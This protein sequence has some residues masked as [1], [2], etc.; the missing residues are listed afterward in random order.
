MTIAAQ[1]LIEQIQNARARIRSDSVHAAALMRLQAWQVERLRATY[2]DYHV[3]PRYRDALDFFAEDLYGPHDFQ[4]RDQDLGRV[5][6]TWHR[7][8]PARAVDAVTRALEL[9]VLSLSLDLAVVDALGSSSLSPSTYARAY[10]QAGRRHDRQRQ[11]WLILAAG[12]SLD[13]LVGHAWVQPMLR[14][15]RAPARL[16]GMKDLHTFLE[17]GYAAFSKM[18][19]AG[20]L[21]HAIEHRETE[22]MKNL[23]AAAA[24]PFN[25]EHPCRT[26][27]KA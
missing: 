24:N 13:E 19:G 21:L 27:R 9:E 25:T 23:F 12:R 8:L 14:M 7:I 4:A 26:V 11:I 22:I 1:S 17:R 16:A 5:V 20:D 2:A 3:I 6:Q 10:R 15:A 18:G